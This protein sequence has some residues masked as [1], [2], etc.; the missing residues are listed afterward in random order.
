MRPTADKTNHFL[1][2]YRELY[3]HAGYLEDVLEGLIHRRGVD[4]H[5]LDGH[6]MGILHALE[7]SHKRHE[8]LRF[9]RKGKRTSADPFHNQMVKVSRVVQEQAAV[10]LKTSFLLDKGDPGF[11]YLQTLSDVHDNILGAFQNTLQNNV[12]MPVVL[13]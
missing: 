5:E 3:G 13:N 7:D 11:E 6:L 2:L 4:R 10:L 8:T 1:D 9:T 12:L